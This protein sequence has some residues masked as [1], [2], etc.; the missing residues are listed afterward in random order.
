MWRTVCLRVK[1]KVSVL[2]G[3]NDTNQVSA[4]C[5]IL[6]GSE[7]RQYAAVTGS[8][9]IIKRLVSSTNNRIF[10]QISVTISLMYNKNINH[11]FVVRRSVLR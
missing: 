10:E 8:S 11:A 7:L 5:E 6:S 3:L 1:S 4:H 2:A 9:T